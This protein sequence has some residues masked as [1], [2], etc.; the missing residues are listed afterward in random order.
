M[1][2]TIELTETEAA[3]LHASAT[4]RGTDEMTVLH[5]LIADLQ[6]PAEHAHTRYLTPQ[7]LLR[8]SSQE[9][10]RYIRS[11][12]EDAAPLYAAD[13]ALLP[14]DREMTALTTLAGESYRDEGE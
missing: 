6:T 2:L 5:E 3:Q 11:A 13:V 1:T 4:A 8:M 9:Q 14:Q 7:E 12:A 10:D